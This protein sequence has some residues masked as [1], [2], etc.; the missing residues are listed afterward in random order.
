AGEWY[1]VDAVSRAALTRWVATQRALT[2]G[3]LKVL[4][5]GD[6]EELWVTTSP[7]RPRAGRPAPPAGLPAVVR[8]LEAAHR[9]LTSLALG[10]PLLLEQFCPLPEDAA[11]PGNPSIPYNVSLYS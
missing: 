4:N 10:S 3:H 8:T 11:K 2:A 7:G 1:P 5:G 6:V 9:K